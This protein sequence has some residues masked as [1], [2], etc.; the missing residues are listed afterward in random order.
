MK[1]SLVSFSLLILLGL[2]YHSYTQSISYSYRYENGKLIYTYNGNDYD[3]KE[4]MEDAIQ[5]DY[6][7]KIFTFGGDNNNGK[8]R[9]IDISKWKGNNTF[10]N[11]IFDEIWEGYNYDNDKAKNFKVM[12]TKLF[13]EQNKY[14]IAHGA[15]KLIKSK[16][17]EKKAQA[18]AEVIARLGRLEHDPKNR[19]EGTGENL[20]YGTTFIGH[21]AVKGWYDEIAL[22]N[23][24]KPGFS[25]ATGHFTQLVWKGTTHAGFGVVEKG[26]RVYVVCKYSPPGNYPRQFEANVLQHAATQNRE[27][28]TEYNENIARKPSL[29][30]T[31]NAPGKKPLNSKTT[32]R[33]QKPVR[34]ASKSTKRPI[35]TTRKTPK[36]TKRPV[37]P[38]RKTPKTTKRPVKTTKP[39]LKTTKRPVTTTKSASVTTKAPKTPAKPSSVATKESTTSKVVTVSTAK[40]VVTEKPPNNRIDPKYIPSAAEV[41][42]LYTFD[43]NKEK[44]KN[45]GP[46]SIKVYDEVWKGYDYK[47]DFKTGYLDMRD[48]ILKETNRYRQAH[49]VGPLTY[50]YDL[51]KASQE[52]AKYLGDNNLFDHDPKNDQNG[53]GENLA[54]F[55]ASIGS[56]ATKKWYDE[57]DMYDFSKNQFSYDTGHF[58][59]LVWKDTKKVGCGI[60]LKN[61][62]LYVVCKYTP[63]GNFMNEF[64]KN[65]F[66]RLPEYN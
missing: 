28:R 65:V 63:Q 36:T 58:T 2:I 22:Y 15:K 62:D 4:A 48:R 12:K 44:V 21:L 61:E 34:P 53:W 37:K 8:K 46:F 56:L 59:Q 27:D 17:L 54:R 52:Y 35:K 11:K 29:I 7:D 43:V 10:S 55:S 40:P 25:P 13:N 57:V 24:K 66:Q 6:P 30:S 64:S 26:D 14:R 16:D 49:G 18:Y 23:F 47:K 9:K 60:Y 51:E 50:D 42:K 41:D 38:T 3:T 45:S 19:I 1:H 33:S 31:N 20:A 5:R 32:P 39:T